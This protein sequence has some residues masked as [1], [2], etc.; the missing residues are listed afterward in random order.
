[1]DQ[2]AAVGSSRVKQ[3]RTTSFTVL[4]Q[5]LKFGGYNSGSSS[6]GGRSSSSSGSSSTQA[7]EQQLPTG[8]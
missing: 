2:G 7:P 4:Q 5:G 6:G 8:P 3:Q 1:V